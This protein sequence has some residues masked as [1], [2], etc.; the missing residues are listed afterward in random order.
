MGLVS[1]I[2]SFFSKKVFFK[3]ILTFLYQDPRA[4]SSDGM[5][6]LHWLMSTNS[7]KIYKKVKILKI[8]NYGTSK[9]TFKRTSGDRIKF[10]LK[11]MDIQ[12]GVAH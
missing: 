10:H 4:T 3:N 11:F 9:L 7:D 1:G 2:I 5:T 8:C 12:I 6:S